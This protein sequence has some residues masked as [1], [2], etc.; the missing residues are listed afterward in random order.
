M[1]DKWLLPSDSLCMDII[2]FCSTRE[3]SPCPACQANNKKGKE[4]SIWQL[5][6]AW[7]V[8]LISFLGVV[9]FFSH[10]EELL[11]AGENMATLQTD[12]VS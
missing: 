10:R 6:S 11:E 1:R 2:R 4:N 8:G 9:G 3:N 5:F 12:P 7:E